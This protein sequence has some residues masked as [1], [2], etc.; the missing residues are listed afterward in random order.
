[1]ARRTERF[2]DAPY[3]FVQIRG[4]NHFPPDERPADVAEAI[5]DRVRSIND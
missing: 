3:R 5:I 1:V 2:V 4:A